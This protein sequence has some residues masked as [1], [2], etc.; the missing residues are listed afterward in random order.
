MIVQ[1]ITIDRSNR[2]PDEFLDM[3][4]E[5]GTGLLIDVR[6]FPRSRSDPE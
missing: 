1:F 2:S 4:R 5:A 6:S 3:L